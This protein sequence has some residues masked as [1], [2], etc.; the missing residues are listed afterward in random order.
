MAGVAPCELAIEEEVV[1]LW[2]DPTE[3][4]PGALAG[5]AWGGPAPG[6]L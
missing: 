5:A 6:G 1:V 2:M 3:G 4:L